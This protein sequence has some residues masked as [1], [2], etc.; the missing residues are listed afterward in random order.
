MTQLSTTSD[1]LA[2][3]HE[4][5]IAAATEGEFGPPESPDEWSA[6]LIVAHAIASDR[7]YVSAVSAVLI[8][9]ETVFNNRITQSRAYL[10]TIVAGAGDWAGL[11]ET[12]RR[13]AIEAQAVGLGL[14]DAAWSL[15]IP[16]SVGDGDVRQQRT[17][18]LRDLAPVSARHITS[19][20]EQLN[21]LKV[22]R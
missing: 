19:H 12:A 15:E 8:G 18:V 5:F 1:A 17:A 9:M 13:S 7:L 22:S 2:Q 6:E 21:A 3:A 11:I 10:E 20:V 16:M 4:A 14:D